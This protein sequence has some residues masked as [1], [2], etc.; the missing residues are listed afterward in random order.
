MVKRWTLVTSL[1]ILFLSCN[2]SEI[3]QEEE[4]PVPRFLFSVPENNASDIA[5]NS[6]V[7][8]AYNTPIVRDATVK[9]LVNDQPV[10][11]E[12]AER[13][14]VLNISLEKNHTYQVDVPHGAVKNKNGVEAG[15]V[16][17]RFSTLSDSRLLEAENAALTGNAVIENTLDNFSGSG[18][19]NQ[20]EGD[21]SFKIT[22]PEGGR[23]KL[24][25][26]FSNGNNKKENDLVVNGV[27]LSSL[28]F[29][30]S[31]DWKT[32]TIEKVVLKPGENTITL[33]KNWGW[34]YLDYLEIAPADPETPF[35]I[36][37]SLT[38]ADASEE[39]VKVYNFLKEQWGK[40]VIAGA[41][42]NYSTGTEEALWMYENTGKWPAIAG[43][44]FI[45][46]TRQWSFVN[47]GELVKNAD[48]WWQN[49]GLVTLMWHWR[50]PLRKTDAFYTN[51]TGFDIT[52]IE[53]TSSPEYKA[54]LADI[55]SIAVYLKQLQAKNIPVLWRPLHEASGK[56]FWW[57]AG[58]AEPCKKLWIMM[59]E[60][61]T[62]YHKL[63]NL[64]W[65]WTSD[66][67][68][69]APEW[70]PGHEYVDLIGMDIYPGENQHGSQ[71]I[72]FDK[73]KKHFGGRKIIALTECGSV[74]DIDSMFDFGDTWSWFMPWNGDY[75]RSDMHN[76]AEYL[77][78]VFNNSKVLT[79]SDLPDLK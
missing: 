23:Y 24:S 27:K 2:K 30:A 5:L 32:L 38:T 43:F 75:T 11:T 7:S 15:A 74:P 18:Y 56:W 9:V 13:K 57:G 1:C 62:Y 61:L 70:Y 12:V 77:K 33:R 31:Q 63:N 51:E 67:A 47:Y 55:D 73:V 19:V 3:P 25:F 64:I 14:L 21:I 60:R 6:E 26:R 78:N 45:N 52:Q 40:K 41:M 69:D 50:D 4:L 20:K 76:G 72:A 36:D 17:F 48:E 53:H 68:G 59:Y 8:L 16:S 29:D 54:M 34:I 65:V 44:D 39:A 42:A 28:V 10:E 49:N 35:A 66:A 71:Y 22:L 46:Y 37:A 79:R 58:G